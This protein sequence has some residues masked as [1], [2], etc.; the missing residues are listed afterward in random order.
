[1]KKFFYLITMVLPASLMMLSSCSKDLVSNPEESLSS[2]T[3][4]ARLKSVPYKDDLDTYYAP[5]PGP[6][7]LYFPGGGEGNATHMGKANTFFNQLATFGPGGEIT[8]SIGAPVNMFFAADLANAGIIG[9]PS[10]VN[11]IVFDKKGNSIWFAPAPGGSSTTTFINPNRIEFSGVSD[12]VGGTG[13]FN[14]ASGQVN[15]SGYFNPNNQQ[16][17]GV[18]SDGRISY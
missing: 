9:V 3:Q 13:K 10:N 5:T 11:S 4:K 7:G 1:M 12:I 15:V 17:A 14:G 6:G 2:A 18:A 8:G 16:D